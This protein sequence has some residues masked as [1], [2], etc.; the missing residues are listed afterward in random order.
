MTD[1]KATDWKEADQLKEGLWLQ[2]LLCGGSSIFSFWCL[3]NNNCWDDNGHCSKSTAL[4]RESWVVLQQPILLL[5]NLYCCIIWTAW[6]TLVSLCYL[7]SLPFLTLDQYLAACVVTAA[8][9]IC[10]DQEQFHCFVG[11]TFQSINETTHWLV[12]P[13]TQTS[14]LASVAVLQHHTTSIVVADR[15]HMLSAQEQVRHTQRTYAPNSQ[16]CCFPSDDSLK[17]LNCRS[18]WSGSN[19]KMLSS[20]VF[21]SCANM[22]ST[23]YHCAI[24][25]D[26]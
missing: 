10:T 14:S 25:I 17:M 12:R 8:L 6:T 1:W 13:P 2:I 21:A 23:D 5:L 20:P 9:S 24:C 22:N 16:F 11:L 26:L 19:W 18:P 7:I 15:Q 4:A 3:R